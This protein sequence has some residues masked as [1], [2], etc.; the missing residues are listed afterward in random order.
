M[1]RRAVLPVPPRNS[2]L[3]PPFEKEAL[4][5]V[6]IVWDNVKIY[7]EN[8]PLDI[9]GFNIYRAFDAPTNFVKLNSTPVG[10]LSYRDATQEIQ[11]IDEDVSSAFLSRGDN[12]S[13]DYVFQV[14]NRPIVEPGKGKITKNLLS[15][16]I[17]VDGTVVSPLKVI[18]LTGE[19]F[20]RTD[21]IYD[22]DQDDVNDPVL[23]GP[24][25]VVKATYN[26]LQNPIRIFLARR[27]LYKVIPVLGDGKETP[28]DRAETLDL[29]TWGKKNFIWEEAVFRNRWLLDQEGEQ[30]FL[31]IR[32]YQGDPCP[33]EDPADTETRRSFRRDCKTCFGTGIQGGFEG[34]FKIEISPPQE[35]KSLDLTDRGL[36]MEF[37]H[38]TW[39]GPTPYITRG[40]LI[41]K[42]NGA[43]FVVGPVSYIRCGQ[44]LLQQEFPIL[45]LDD[46]DPYYLISLAS[47]PD[48]GTLPEREVNANIEEDRQIRDRRVFEEIMQ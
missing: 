19:V 28:L 37:I 11:V 24:A 6:D 36:K 2:F 13:G 18:G 16:S 7:P 15:V 14:A 29:N 45:E 48:S 21:H 33:Q 47:G 3:I 8:V 32:K 20:L 9:V 34:P 10:S 12:S 41:V 27:L 42:Q 22:I 26:Y 23:P 39:T 46:T 38:N 31:M 17:D 30:V 40:D 44:N 1:A 35:E 4:P 5:F 25:S 43:R